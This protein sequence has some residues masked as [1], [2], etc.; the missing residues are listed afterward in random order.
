[1]GQK[2]TNYLHFMHYLLS[3]IHQNDQNTFDACL[4]FPPFFDP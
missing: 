3:E 2:D 1:M 4:I